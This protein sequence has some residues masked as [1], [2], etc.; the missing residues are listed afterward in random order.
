MRPEKA[1]YAHSFLYLFISSARVTQTIALCLILQTKRQ[2]EH[3]SEWMIYHQH[4]CKECWMLILSKIYINALPFL[5][6]A[7]HFLHLLITDEAFYWCFRFGLCR[8][9]DSGQWSTNWH[10]MSNRTP[11]SQGSCWTISSP[12]PVCACL[13]KRWQL[14]CHSVW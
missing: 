3:C 5:I 12:Q 8:P 14:W 2:E 9:S 1:L 13:Y 7:P 11:K 6:S 10:S 4:I